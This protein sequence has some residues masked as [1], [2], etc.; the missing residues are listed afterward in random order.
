MR[1][2]L[3]RFRHDWQ[4]MTHGGSQVLD[5]RRCRRCGRFD[6]WAYSRF[7]QTNRAQY[8]DAHDVDRLSDGSTAVTDRQPATA[9]GRALWDWAADGAQ[10]Y[11]GTSAHV[12]IGE[13]IAQVEAAAQ[14]L[15]S[16]SCLPDEANADMFRQGYEAGHVH[17]LAERDEEVR[18]LMDV[19]ARYTDFAADFLSLSTDGDS[20][21]VR[22]A[23]SA[24]TSAR[25]LLLA[26]QPAP[27]EPPR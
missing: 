23:R 11:R 21:V 9:A 17:G 24:A 10:M 4:A 3:C 25:A 8:P 1:P 7:Y 19:M 2:L 18:R 12:Q 20:A 5:A 13:R 16:H 26:A 14:A 22:A 6:A 15:R 27:P